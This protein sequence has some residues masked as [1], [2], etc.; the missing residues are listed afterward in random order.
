M[1]AT[2]ILMQTN[3][4]HQELL[5][6]GVCIRLLIQDSLAFCIKTVGSTKR[7]RTLL[8]RIFLIGL[9]VV[10]RPENASFEKARWIVM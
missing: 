9:A 6:A 2:S 7:W 10:E 3:N 4:H 1:S 5:F 8:L